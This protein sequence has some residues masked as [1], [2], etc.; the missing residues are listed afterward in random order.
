M[1]QRVIN[2]CLNS[3]GKGPVVFSTETLR[4]RFGHLTANGKH[5]FAVSGF[6]LSVQDSRVVAHNCHVCFYS[7]LFTSIL[8]E[9][10]CSKLRFYVK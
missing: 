2:H 9:K 1:A 4:L 3:A 10:S 6:T 5:W 8:A 7:I